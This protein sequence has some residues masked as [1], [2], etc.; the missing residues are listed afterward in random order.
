MYTYESDSLVIVFSISRQFTVCPKDFKSQLN[1]LMYATR[2]Q[3][4][5]KVEIIHKKNVTYFRF[6]NTAIYILSWS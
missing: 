3:C 6:H 4:T 2:M 1:Q 5:K